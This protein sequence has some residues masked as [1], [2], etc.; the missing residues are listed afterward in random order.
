MG[1]KV[2]KYQTQK[3]QAKIKDV[4]LMLADLETGMTYTDVGRK[5]GASKQRI[6]QIAQREGF[7][8][9]PEGYLTIAEL[10]KLL[11]LTPQGVSE[12]IKR[13]RIR[14]VKVGQKYYIPKENYLAR[15]CAECGQNPVPLNLSRYCS[16]ECRDKAIYKTFKRY[17]WKRFKRK[18]AE[19][20]LSWWMKLRRKI[21]KNL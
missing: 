12:H 13:G 19:K 17:C 15:I 7:D 20:E 8:P 5:Y 21:S 16:R 9:R 6:H 10:A 14:A 4:G 2:K 1:R 11:N 3:T 18:R